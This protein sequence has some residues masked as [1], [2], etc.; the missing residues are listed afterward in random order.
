LPV[1][2]TSPKYTPASEKEL[3]RDTVGTQRLGLLDCKNQKSCTQLNSKENDA[4]MR[5]RIKLCSAFAFVFR[6]GFSLKYFVRTEDSYAFCTTARRAKAQHPHAAYVYLSRFYPLFD[7]LGGE[8]LR[9]VYSFEM[10]IN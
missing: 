4:S 1:T 7:F 5:H 8:I 3:G 9:L 10:K 2:A 6:A